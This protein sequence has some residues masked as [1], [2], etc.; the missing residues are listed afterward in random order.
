M[1]EP[2]APSRPGL[3]VLGVLLILGGMVL[4]CFGVVLVIGTIGQGP[5]SGIGGAL[6]GLGQ[7]AGVLGILIGAGALLLGVVLVRPR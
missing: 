6:T 4:A 7:A 3:R 1:H 2:R 5:T